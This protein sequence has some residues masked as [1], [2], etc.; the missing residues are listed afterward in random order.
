MRRRSP[1]TV[2]RSPSDPDAPWPYYG[3]S[4]SQLAL[5]HVETSASFSRC[6][7]ILPD[8][9]WYFSS[10]HEAQRLGI[11]TFAVSHSVNFVKQAGWQNSSSPYVMYIAALASMR[12]KLPDQ[13]AEFLRDIDAHVEAGSWQA[14]IVAFLAGR[15]TPEAFL[16]KASPKELLTEAHAYIGIK[17]NIEGDRE[18]ARRT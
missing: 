1:P 16:A 10:L 8:P 18:T 13:A 11:D 14:A 3:L 2:R 9:G 17:A 4:V 15:L 6:L 5:G 12:K 7:Q